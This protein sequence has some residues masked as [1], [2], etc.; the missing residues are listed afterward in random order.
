[1]RSPQKPSP[2]HRNSIQP[3]FLPL[4][5]NK[6]TSFALQPSTTPAGKPQRLWGLNP[7]HTDLLTR[8]QFCPGVTGVL[9]VRA[10]RFFRI[11]PHLYE[12]ART[13]SHFFWRL[14]RKFRHEP[15]IFPGNSSIDEVRLPVMPPDTSDA[16]SDYSPSSFHQDK[17][18]TNRSSPACTI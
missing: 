15:L 7:Q 18:Q 2:G 4:R 6:P 11:L 17:S 14:V 9:L 16:R 1:M 8:P 10:Q 5:P 12:I 13:L 3:A